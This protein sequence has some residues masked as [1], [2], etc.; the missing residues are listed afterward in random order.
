MISLLAFFCL[1]SH[2]TVSISPEHLLE[3]PIETRVREFKAQGDQGVRSLRAIAF[4]KKQPLRLRWPALTTIGRWDA[5]HFRD[6][7]D[8]ALASPDWFMRNAALIALKND[9]RT[10]AVAWSMKLLSDP[11]LVIRTQAVRNLIDLSA[12]EAEPDLWK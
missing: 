5:I 12:I 2:A 8:R 4:D 1:Q 6:D 7:L 11:A 9:E 10:R 3:S